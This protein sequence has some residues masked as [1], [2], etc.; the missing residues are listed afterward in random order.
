MFPEWFMDLSL[1][2]SKLILCLFPFRPCFSEILRRPCA[3]G[4]GLQKKDR[5]PETVNDYP[6]NPGAPKRDCL[7]YVEMIA[8][9][10]HFMLEQG[11]LGSEQE[12]KKKL[13][14]L[15][16]PF[17]Q[18]PVYFCI[19]FGLDAIIHDVIGFLIGFL[20]RLSWSSG[21]GFTLYSEKDALCLSKGIPF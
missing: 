6:G 19:C 15:S 5:F 1:P 13:F 16:V 18:L 3:V 17:K 11:N 21:E 20:S 8:N 10:H 14:A 4:L 12:A 9:A 2:L 7:Q